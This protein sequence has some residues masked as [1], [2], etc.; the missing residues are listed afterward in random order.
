[1]LIGIPTTHEQFIATEGI[2]G[3]FAEAFAGRWTLYKTVVLAELERAIQEWVTTGVRC[4]RNASV[5]DWRRY[6]Q[7]QGA[8]FLFSH[9]V[10]GAA[11][12]LTCGAVANADLAADVPQTFDGV[13]DL[14]ACRGK[15]LAMEIRKRVK[16]GLIRFSDRRLSVDTWATYF[17]VLFRL[18]GTGEH[19]Y[20]AAS[21]KATSLMLGGA[22]WRR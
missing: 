22:R 17:T 7:T 3:L 5:L 4:I 21:E 16:G 18:L 8:V 15:A 12:E 1:M 14:C 19:G 11:I 13:L 6:L 20:L 10:R 9:S 2:P